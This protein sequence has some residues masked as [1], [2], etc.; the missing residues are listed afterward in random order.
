MLQRPGNRWLLHMLVSTLERVHAL[1]IVTMKSRPSN[2]FEPEIRGPAACTSGAPDAVTHWS[3]HSPV[4]DPQWNC[5]PV[6]IVPEEQIVNVGDVAGSGGGSILLEQAHEVAELPVQ[7]T[8]KL[9]GGCRAG[10]RAE[11]HSCMA[12]Q[13]GDGSCSTQHSSINQLHSTRRGH[14]AALRHLQH[15]RHWVGC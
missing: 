1:P 10:H 4:N 12:E 11:S 15:T 13:S 8:K 3:S 2:Q 7:V 14:Q 6:H 9:D 5:P